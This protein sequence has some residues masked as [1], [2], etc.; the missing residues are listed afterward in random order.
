ML[1]KRGMKARGVKDCCKDFHLNN[2]VDG[3]AI[4]QVRIQALGG[5]DWKGKVISPSLDLLRLRYPLGIQEKVIPKSLPLDPIFH[6]W[7]GHECPMSL[8]PGVSF[9]NVWCSA[10]C[11]DHSHLFWMKGWKNKSR[12][13]VDSYI[14][15]SSF[16][17][18]SNP[19]ILFQTVQENNNFILHAVPSVHWKPILW[20]H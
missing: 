20:L 9:W 19:T 14:G 16:Y 13:S 17:P 2:W 1:S 11:L 5:E 10:L 12:T 18:D 4:S 3:V 15:Q 7:L 8:C 6:L